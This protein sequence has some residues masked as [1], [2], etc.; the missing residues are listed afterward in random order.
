VL[1]WAFELFAHYGYFVIVAGVLLENAGIPAPGHTVV[2]VGACLAQYGQL[3]ILWVAVC[4][5]AAA[6]V[7]DN[8]GYWI[9]HWKGRDLL[10][11]HRRLFH[12]PPD[13]ERRVAE[14]FDHHGPKAVVIGRFIAGFQSIAAIMA[15]VS[16]MRWRTFCL[17]NVLGAIVWSA[18][19]SALGYLAGSSIHAID[20]WAGRIGLA[21]ICLVI[22][23][24]I[25]Y[26]IWRHHHAD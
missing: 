25:G 13:R 21:L 26:R 11:R 19:L 12:F 15:G 24:G 20:R 10:H 5:C 3:S 17:W 9:G 18:S 8:I 1:H 14:F 2:L 23:G 22:L 16:R 6:V 7:G 4:A